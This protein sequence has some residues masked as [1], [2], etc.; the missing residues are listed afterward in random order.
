MKKFLLKMIAIV[1]SEF[2]VA[3]NG[4]IPWSF[5]E[6]LKFF[7]EKTLHS[8][9][10]MGRVTFFSIPNAPLHDRINYVISKSL[11]SPI[12]N[13]EIFSSLESALKNIEN[14][15]N[16]SNKKIPEVWI[17]GGASL[18]NYALEKDLIDEAFITQ[19]HQNFYADQFINSKFL[20]KMNREI[21]FSEKNYSIIRFTKK[22]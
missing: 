6:D 22:I 4:K 5:E 18:Y 19:V 3:K 14:F 15:S 7:R 9:I 17:I 12:P 8:I 20:K 16:F 1:D 2:G 11:K 21:I 10:I 13:I